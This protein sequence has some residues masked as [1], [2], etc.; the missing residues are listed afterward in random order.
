MG[1]PIGKCGW[2]DRRGRRC[3]QPAYTTGDCGPTYH[4]VALRR[5][6][7]CPRHSAMLDSIH[8]PQYSDVRGQADAPRTE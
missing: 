7:L 5:Q 2:K 1:A 4:P 6:P 3:D 8:K